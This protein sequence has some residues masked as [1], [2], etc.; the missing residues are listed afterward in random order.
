M[1]PALL[2]ALFVLPAT[3]ALAHHPDGR[4]DE[5]IASREPAFAKIDV[6]APEVAGIEAAGLAGYADRIIVLNVVPEDCGAPC[7][8]QVKLLADAQ[9]KIAVSPM[10][11]MVEFVSVVPE[12]EAAG[13]AA[14]HGL[15]PANWEVRGAADA[16]VEAVGAGLAATLSEGGAAGEPV[17]YVFDH[18]GRLAAAFRGTGF[19][20][21]N[22][23][24]YVNGLTNAM[25]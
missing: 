14:A 12:A 4:L 10:A 21:L 7:E 19:Q 22:L 5:E 24:L 1:R 15:D 25:E 3:A 13:F 2:A 6:M 18:G 16:E 11:S 9:A 17:T 8:D 23:V 20:P